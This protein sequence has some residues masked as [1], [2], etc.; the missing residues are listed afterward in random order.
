[1]SYELRLEFF[2]IA[3]LEVQGTL[4]FRTEMAMWG[5]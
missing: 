5:V 3:G 4:T 2:N 1:M